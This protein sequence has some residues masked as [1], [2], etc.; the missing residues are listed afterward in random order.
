MEK[1]A[2]ILTK[3]IAEL[4][5]HLSPHTIANVQQ[6]LEGTLRV[7]PQTHVELGYNLCQFFTQ[8]NDQPLQ[9]YIDTIHHHLVD[10]GYPE[11]NIVEIPALLFH[12]DFIP[13]SLSPHPKA[14]KSHY[15]VPLYTPVNGVQMNTGGES[16]NFF[17]VGGMKLLDQDVTEQLSKIGIQHIPLPSG[18][19]LGYA[20]SGF[21]CVAV[22]WR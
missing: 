7:A 6:Y 22:P 12:N 1:F 3:S 19:C 8:D 5:G 16:S 13:L 11:K 2:G 10:V 20:L 4:A 21:R 17:T 15:S 14:L 9:E 18:I